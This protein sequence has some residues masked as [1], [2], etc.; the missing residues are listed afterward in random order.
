VRYLL[1]MMASK[2]KTS[3]VKVDGAGVSVC[4]R[5]PYSVW[6]FR[7]RS[8]FAKSRYCNILPKLIRF[9]HLRG[10]ERKRIH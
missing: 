9:V 4:I 5:S 6:Y 7:A 2:I 1:K 10:L 3:I 8:L